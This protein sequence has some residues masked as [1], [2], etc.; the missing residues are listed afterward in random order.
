MFS[1]NEDHFDLQRFI[2]AQELMYPY[3]L[4]E[5]KAGRKRSHWMWFVFPQLEGLGQSA[6]AIKFS[7]KSKDEAM[8]YLNH[9]ILG[10]RLREIT[11]E[12]LTLEGKS[13]ADIFGAPDDMKLKSS[14]T[15]FDAISP[16]DIFND[17]IDKYC[18]SK[19]DFQT[20]AILENL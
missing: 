16:N 1:M 5:I 9:S 17:V 2:D 13:V 3:A 8:A 11:E 10:K 19:Q 6:T 4:K 20:V 7:I 15:L 18:E 14:M 12:L